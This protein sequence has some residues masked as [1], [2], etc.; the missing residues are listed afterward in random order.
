[1]MIGDWALHPAD[2]TV[3]L[4]EEGMEL[5]KVGAKEHGLGSS[6]KD[7]D[8]PK[9][10]KKK[11]SSL[12]AFFSS[13]SSKRPSEAE[14]VGDAASSPSPIRRKACR[15]TP[16]ALSSPAYEMLSEDDFDIDGDGGSSPTLK[17]TERDSQPKVLPSIALID[18]THCSTARSKRLDL[19]QQHCQLLL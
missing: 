14:T 7:T 11:Q 2:A 1:M 12:L 13:P 8:T 10:A 17:K 19:C 9:S 18:D 6:I 15:A 4:G 16:L 3:E 5:D